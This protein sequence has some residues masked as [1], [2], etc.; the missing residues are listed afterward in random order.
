MCLA[1]PCCWF[2]YLLQSISGIAL[3]PTSNKLYSGGRDGMLRIWDCHSGKCSEY[4]RLGAE[5]G[6]V[7]CD[8]PWVFVGIP[9]SVKVSWFI[10]KCWLES[11][12][13]GNF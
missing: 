3:P 10:L 7:I 13:F 11:I 4:I 12:V 5:A 1:F 9:N 8:G 2:D 6:S